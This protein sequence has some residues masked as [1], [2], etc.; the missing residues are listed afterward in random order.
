[1]KK[2]L[3]RVTMFVMIIY[4]TCG[5]LNPAVTASPPSG[6]NGTHFRGV[7]DDRWNKQDSDQFPN[8][9]YARTAAANLDV[10]EPRTVRLIYFTPNDW[11]YRADIVQQMK[12]DILTIQTFY[13]EQMDAHGYGKITFRI[14]TD[15]QGEPMVHRVDGKRPF[16]HYDNTLGSKVFSELE[17]AFD[18]KANIYFIVLG[19]DAL[20]QEGGAPAGGVGYRFAKNGGA[21]LVPNE[22]SWD[23]VAHELGHAFGLHHDFRDDAY[24]MSY[25]LEQDRLSACAAEFLAVHPYF[26]SQT[27]IEE[28]SVPSI[29]HISS[30]KYTAGARNVPIRFKVSDFRGLHQVLLYVFHDL[31]D[32]LKVCRGLMGETNAI[33]EFDYDGVIPSDGSTK[34]SNPIVHAMR[35]VVVNTDGDVNSEHFGLSEFSSQHIVTFPHQ[36]PV[37]SV[38]FSQG[39]EFLACGTREAVTVWN[40]TTWQLVNTLRH[41]DWVSSVSFSPTDLPILASGAEDD[42]VN[43]WNAV[44]T[45]KIATLEGHTHIVSSVSFSRDGK[46]L[47]SGSFDNTIKLWDVATQAEIATLEG[48]TDLVLSVSFSPTD[49]LILAS[50]SWDNTVKLWNVARQR[51]I[52]TL[53]GHTR[54]AQTV[55]FSPNGTM[56]AAGSGDG[57]ITLWNVVTREIIATYRAHREEIDSVSFSHD[58]KTLA[59]G[60]FDNTIKLWDIAT[61]EEITTLEG[62]THWVHSVSFSP[63]GAILASASQDSTAMLWEVAE[64][65]EERIR[66]RT[67]IDIPDPN[68]RAAIENEL[69]LASGATITTADMAGLTRLEAGNANI[70]DLTGLEGAINLTSLSLSGN[71]ISDISPLVANTG[72]GSGDVVNVSENPLNSASINTHIPALQTRG[73]TVEFS[74]DIPDSNLRAKIEEALGKASGATITTADMANLTTLYDAENA[75]ITNLTGLETAT[76]LTSL[77]IWG[78]SISDISPLANLTHLTHLWLSGN[79]ISDLSPLANLTNLTHLFFGD[80]RIS[81]ISPLANLTNLTR[82]SLGQNIIS[83]ISPLANLTNLTQLNLGMNAI[84]D[85]SPLAG[86]NN[87]TQ[88]LLFNNPISD[89]SSLANL[90]NLTELSL[91]ENIISDISAVAGLTNLTELT[92]DTNSISDISPLANLTNLTQLFLGDNRISDI[93]PLANLTNLTHVWLSGNTISNISPLAGLNNLTRLW[94]RNNSISDISPLVTNT[95]LGEG[96]DVNVSENPLSFASINDHIP[97]LRSRGVEVH[98]YNLKPTTSEFT[99]SIPAGISLIHIPLRVTEVNGAAQTIGLIS[100]LYDALG[101]ASKVNFLITYDTISQDW[102]SYFAP[103]DKGGPADSG[104]GDDTGI[105]V[106]LR[107]PVSVHLRGNPLGTNGNSAIALG[108][109]LNVVGLPLNDSRITRVSDLFDL[110]GI[111]GNVPVIILTDDG[112][113]KLVGHAGDPGD[114]AITGGQAFIMTASRAATV[115]ISGD[116]WANG[117]GTAAAPPV[118]L[119]GVEVGDTTPVLGLRGAIVDE[120]TGLNN[121]GFRVTVK[122]LSTGRAVAAV[123]TPDEAGYRSTVVDIETGRAATVGDILEISAQ[124]PNP[125]IGVQPLQYTVTAED[126]KHS[127]IQLPEL[128][129]YEIPAETELLHNYPNPFNPETWIPYRLAEDAFVTLTIYD[130]SGQVVRTLDVGHRI[131]AVYENRSKAIYWDGRNGLGEQVASGVYF[132]HLSAGAYS[133]T[134]R[135]VILK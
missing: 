72:L 108:Q 118:T 58:G 43:L 18:F 10:G 40:V 21:F 55:S 49:P 96:A 38:A 23:T 54:G 51:D 44:T 68:L 57:T 110:D 117:A 39:G 122:N 135:L 125:F 114:I 104:L 3:L 121:A 4:V 73:V 93:S 109:G 14:E 52:A 29:E 9:H 105:I 20:R 124:S 2:E 16:S 107:V 45:E 76:N 47:A 8:R 88:L 12:D 46:T 87:L 1:M 66:A 120:G 42:T 5:V 26:N 112:E 102:Y 78:N 64:S 99:L 91:W 126:V 101:G 35:A 71:S 115:D 83:D 32:E 17:Q 90:T 95:G 116:A 85:I 82:L 132:Y 80:N 75:N 62:H 97:T 22:F 94:V 41:N 128:V 7:I 30:R 56:L 67:E 6:G 13:A 50:G 129:A 98:A 25:G 77:E 11:Q 79:T 31:G 119:K 134:R 131:A 61:Q 106:G 33:V 70:S 65:M 53:E 92:L 111:G 28:G 130:Q 123:T 133:A 60:S 81:D 103:S 36:L 100:D 48:H 84:S 127:L 15:S 24:I 37:T 34:L 63:D 27:R 69:G 59:S 74:V 19:T 113:F 86:L 89:I